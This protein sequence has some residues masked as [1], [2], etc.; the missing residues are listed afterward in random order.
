[1]RMT[2]RTPCGAELAAITAARAACGVSKSAAPDTTRSFGSVQPMR[3]RT[4][5]PPCLSSNSSRYT[6]DVHISV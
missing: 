1:M 2:S 3:S 5:I 6:R 4:S